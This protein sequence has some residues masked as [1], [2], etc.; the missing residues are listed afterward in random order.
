MDRSTKFIR[1]SAL[2]SGICVRQHDNL[3]GYDSR[4]EMRLRRTNFGFPQN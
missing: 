2:V 3:V 1:Q 4:Y